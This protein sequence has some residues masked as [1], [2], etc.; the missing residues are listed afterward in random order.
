MTA[1]DET[2]VF[3]FRAR[4][5]VPLD[6]SSQMQENTA[7]VSHGQERDLNSLQIEVSA[8]IVILVSVFIYFIVLS[9]VLTVL[10]KHIFR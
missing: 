5:G 3:E 10:S 7:P 9:L 8:S 1:G 6:V 2:Q 4:P